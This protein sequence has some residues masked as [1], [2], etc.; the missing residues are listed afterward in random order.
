MRTVVSTLLFL[1]LLL[2]VLWS[3]VVDAA[4][5]TS[6]D[7]VVDELKLTG[8]AVNFTGKFSSQLDRL[9]AQPG[10]LLMHEYQPQ[11]D[12]V[13]AII[14]RCRTFT[15]FTSG[16]Q[17]AERPSASVNGSS[18]TADLSSLFLGESS[19]DK[20]KAW[21]IGGM[22]KGLFNPDTL[23]FMLSWDHLLGDEHGSESATFFLQGLVVKGAVEPIPLA[24][25][26]ILFGTGLALV[27]AVWRQKCF[28]G[29]GQPGLSA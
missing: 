25:T 13:A 27:L 9:F 19:G 26:A 11:P 1:P 16:V 8:G 3:P 29:G 2:L 6:S 15:L 5:M 21:N 22:A 10:S 20:L 24:S 28:I 4:V 14:E 12:I 23:E 7:F 18:I 17:G